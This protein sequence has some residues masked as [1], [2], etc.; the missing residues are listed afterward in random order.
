MCHHLLSVGEIWGTP[1]ISSINTSRDAVGSHSEVRTWLRSDRS[2]ISK[3]PSPWGTAFSA[4]IRTPMCVLV[5]RRSASSGRLLWLCCLEFS[6]G[7]MK[8]QMHTGESI[9]K[10]TT[11]PPTW[12]MTSTTDIPVSTTYVCF[13]NE[14]AGILA[15]YDNIS[16]LFFHSW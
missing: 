4:R 12:K 16:W 10:L 3:E 6:S 9:K 7:I 8:R 1:L 11:S 13:I 14:W 5:C 2:I 15:M